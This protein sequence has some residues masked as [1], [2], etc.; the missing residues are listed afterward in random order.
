MR[1]TCLLSL[2][3]ALPAVAAGLVVPREPFANAHLSLMARAKS[4]GAEARLAEVEVWAEGN[5]LRARVRG[6]A[7]AGEFWVEREIVSH[8]VHRL[9]ER[10]PVTPKFG[11]TPREMQVIETVVA[12]Y[13]NK[14]TAERHEYL[15]EHRAAL[16]VAFSLEQNQY[17][18]ETYVELTLAD[19]KQCESLDPQ[20]LRSSNSS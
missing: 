11:L 7:Q 9:T 8:L 4:S 14:E 12:G 3:V 1:R 20:I 10:S 16:D 2:L 19:L 17:N 15:T 18:G 5:R 13:S 6:D